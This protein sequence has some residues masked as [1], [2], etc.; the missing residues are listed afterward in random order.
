MLKA[1]AGLGCARL[2]AGLAFSAPQPTTTDDDRARGVIGWSP[3]PT[4]DPLELFKRQVA[5]PKTC[6]YY[7][8][9]FGSTETITCPTGT[10]MALSPTGT[11]GMVGCCTSVGG[12]MDYQECGWVKRCYDYADVL[13]GLCDE[14]CQIDNFNRV[15]S[16]SSMPYCQSWTC[17]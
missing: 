3:K 6:G 12:R 11:T 5:G 9:G 4:Q 16:A 14:G 2:V 15:C 1:I 13:S 17:K 10:C 7:D 8:D